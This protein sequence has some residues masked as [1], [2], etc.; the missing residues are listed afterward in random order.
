[1]SRT[2]N[3]GRPCRG[4]HVGIIPEEGY[5]FRGK[6]EAQN[7]DDHQQKDGGGFDAEPE[8]LLDPVYSRAP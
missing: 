6:D 5:Q 7:A 1:M 2:G 8:S 4:N 3:A